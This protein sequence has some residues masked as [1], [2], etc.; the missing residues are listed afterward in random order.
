MDQLNSNTDI[1]SRK[2]GKHLS[3]DERGAI[4]AL[5]RQGQSLRAIAAEI[6]CAHTTI[7]YELRRGTPQRT[8]KRG[9]TPI[10]KARR[11]QVAYA[12]HRK[13]CRK[14][15]RLDDTGMEPFIQWVV[16]QVREHHVFCQVEIH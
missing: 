16:G 11:G 4:Q 1:I 6:G 5:H 15:Y 12:E 14:P 7:M 3:L 13:H 2:R 10:Y 8:S 9:R